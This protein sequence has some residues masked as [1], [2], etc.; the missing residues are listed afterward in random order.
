MGTDENRTRNWTNCESTEASPSRQL[1]VPIHGSE[2]KIY[3]TAVESE[4]YKINEIIK[5]SY[6]A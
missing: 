5:K 2:M 1:T 3:I 4:K 6:T